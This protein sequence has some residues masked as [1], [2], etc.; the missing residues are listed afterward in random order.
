MSEDSKTKQEAKVESPKPFLVRVKRGMV[1]YFGDRLREHPEVF[2]VPGTQKLGK[3]M[4]R[5]PEGAKPVM[6]TRKQ[7]KDSNQP[8]IAMGELK[9]QGQY[10]S[11][12]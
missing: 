5:M 11:K 10:G 3:W 1:G 2:E 8:T 12:K 6:P 9:N 7:I 4:E